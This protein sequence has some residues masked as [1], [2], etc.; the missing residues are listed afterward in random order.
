M[1][2]GKF[3]NEP[4]SGDTDFEEVKPLAPE[5]NHAFGYYSFLIYKQ[6]I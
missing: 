3:G 4:K 5:G 2:G 1:E 6:I